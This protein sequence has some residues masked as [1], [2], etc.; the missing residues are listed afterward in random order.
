MV[1]FALLAPVFLAMLGG[2]FEYGRGYWTRQTLEEVAF[3][4]AR[5]MAL[6]DRCANLAA[7]RAFAVSRAAGYA[8]AV[9]PG[10]GV[11]SSGVSC[12]SQ[13]NSHAVTISAVFDSPFRGFLVIPQ[14]LQAQACFPSLAQV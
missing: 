7:Q 2:L 6:E 14:Q 11:A 9:L 8:I 5:C 10:N 3:H 4:T 13:P 12:R 1:E